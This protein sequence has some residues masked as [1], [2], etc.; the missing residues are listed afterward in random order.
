MFS[1]CADKDDPS[2]ILPTPEDT[3]Y[4]LKLKFSE[5]VEFKEILN[6]NDIQDL[7]ETETAYF[8]ER[9][10]WSCPHELQFDRDSL[11]IVKTNNIVEKYKLKWQDKKLFIYQKPIDKWEYC[12]E[13]DENGRVILNIG[14]YIIKNNRRIG[15]EKKSVYDVLNAYLE[16]GL[17][18]ILH[19]IPEVKTVSC[20]LWVKQGSSY[21]SDEFN[22][23]SHLAE[24]LL[25]NAEDVINEQYKYLI[26]EITDNGVMYNAATTKEYTCFHFT[27]LANTLETCICALSHIAMKNRNFETTNFENEKKVVLQE[28]T[29]FYSSFQQIKERTSQALWGNMGIG[30]IIMGNMNNIREAEPDQIKEL[31]RR[32]Y[33]PENSSIV[34]IGNIEYMHVLELIEREFSCWEDIKKETEEEAVDNTPGIYINKGS[35]VSTV[36]S[37]GFRSPGYD[38]QRR[39]PTEMMVRILGGGGF[40]SRIVKEIRTKRGLAYTVGGFASFYRRRGTL[41]FTVVCDKQKSI[42]AAKAMSQVLA[43][44]RI[45]GFLEEEIIREKKVMETNMLLSVD[46]M[47]EHLRYIG[48]CGAMDINFYI[49]NEIRA[50]QKI[51]KEDV[52]RAARQ[53]LV[54]NNMGFA[55][56]G[57]DDAEKLVDAVEI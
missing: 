38:D 52:D 26:A 20:G 43:E 37:I 47:T 34:V 36:L 45:N 57:A 5:K 54:E 56:I 15:K 44:V 17:K 53:L 4:I 50:I 55:A 33:V 30:K 21:E 46:N 3:S 39:L 28:A 49:E 6:K 35:G 51:S 48:K 14:F 31:V 16:N 8:G 1:S 9:I 18:I 7:T 24:H 42:E 23:L 25:M 22:G 32:A 41:G 29:G 13:K 11:S 27:G 2:P 12:G 40:Q 19:K 10:Q